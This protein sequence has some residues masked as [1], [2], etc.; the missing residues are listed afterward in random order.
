M[1]VFSF[2]CVRPAGPV[3]F[4]TTVSYLA[5]FRAS[6][7]SL[8]GPPTSGS[9]LQFLHTDCLVRCGTVLSWDIFIY[10]FAW[11]YAP[12]ALIVLYGS[13]RAIVKDCRVCTSNS[14]QVIE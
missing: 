2:E 11:F 5:V 4:M 8:R 12:H 10:F 14:L 1:C 3:E 7:F 9:V 13:S 6:V